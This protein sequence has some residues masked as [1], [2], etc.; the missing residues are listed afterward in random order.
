MTK[1]KCWHCHEMGHY[2][3]TC[4]QKKRKGKDQMVATSTKIGE[5]AA[6]FEQEF[7]LLAGQSMGG[8]STPLWY[9]DSGAS[10]HMSGVQDMF[11]ELVPRTN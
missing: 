3:V 10:R 5:F 7:A 2:A 9:I 11:S 4:P 1:V 8:S 6:R